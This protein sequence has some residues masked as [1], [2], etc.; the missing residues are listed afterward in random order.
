MTRRKPPPPVVADSADEVEAL[1]YE[2]LAGG[3]LAR[4][5]AL[6]ADDEEIVCVHPNGTRC[7]GPAAVHASF[8]DMLAG[9]GMPVLPEQVHRLHTPDSAVHHL[10]EKIEDEGLEAW[11]LALNVYVRTPAGW[12]MVAHHA[13]PAQGRMVQPQGEAPSTLH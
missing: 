10:V 6:W 4:M 8:E 12:R 3:D 7:V 5:M 13:T 2:A 11:V 1:F 9:G